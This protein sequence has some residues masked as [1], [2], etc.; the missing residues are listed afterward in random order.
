M[1]NLWNL[2]FNG[3]NALPMLTRYGDKVQATGNL[4]NLLKLGTRGAAAN[5]SIKDSIDVVN[6]FPWTQSPQSSR[7]DTPF[8]RMTEQRIVLNSTVANLIYSATA[9][10][11]TVA[12]VGTTAFGGLANQF[13]P[14]E[15]A[16]NTGNTEDIEEEEKSLIASGK[17]KLLETY[18]KALEAGYYKTFA[19]P[20]L[21][22][23]QGLYALEPTGFIYKFPYLD[24][25]YGEVNAQFGEDAGNVGTPITDLLG[26]LASGAAGIAN[27]LRPGTYIEKS[28]QFQMQ[29]LGRAVNFR[30]PLLN[31]NNPDDIARNWQ[32]IFGLI[33]QNRPGRVSKSIIDQPV[34]YEV[35]IPGVTFMPYAFVSRLSVRFLGSRRN[36]AFNVPILDENN[37]AIGEIETTVPDAYEVDMTIQS[38]NDET[39]NMLYA[40]VTKSK[41]TVNAPS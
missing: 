15:G 7:R 29:D 31:T 2:S 10:I 3:T 34:I 35:V 40:N 17:E 27:I 4:K 6:S 38:L 28:K 30:F 36:M 24:D 18:D 22:P 39:R 16:Q 19:N 32:L 11:D 33:Y 13:K 5:A 9:A 25:T 26:G 41:L 23:Y 1:E 8:I 37:I 20:A 12:A 21:K 14:T